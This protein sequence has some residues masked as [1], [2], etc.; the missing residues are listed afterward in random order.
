MSTKR[1]RQGRQLGRAA[2][3]TWAFSVAAV[4]VLAPLGPVGSALAQAPEIE[5]PRTAPMAPPEAPASVR[6]LIDAPYLT[7]DE[8]RD[9]RIFFGR[10]RKDDL[11]TPERA[12]RA[13][14]MR[15]AYDDPALASPEA[16]V[17][18]R[19][20]ALIRR[21]DLNGAIALVRERDE[22]RAR[23]IHAAA[24][25]HM[26]RYPEALEVAARGIATFLKAPPTS[27]DDAV[28][29]VR[30]MTLRLRLAGAAVGAG[31]DQPVAAGAQRIAGDFQGL[32]QILGDARQRLD[33]LH[34]PALLAE[35]ELLYARDNKPKAQEALAELL[36]L[37]PSCADGWRLLG[38][39]TVDGFNFDRSEQVAARLNLLAS[40]GYDPSGEAADVPAGAASIAGAEI[41]AR[42]MLRQ[43]DGEQAVAVLE[44]VLA[45]YP[46]V[47]E[48]LALQA[49]A[50]AVRFDDAARDAALKAFDETVGA[51][52]AALY[53][54]GRALAEARQYAPAA[55]HLD[56]AHQRQ[57]LA[58]EPLIERGLVEVQAGR[59]EQALSAL[60]RAF[61]VDP[62]NLRADNTLRLLREMRSY[63]RIE[64]PHFVVRFKPAEPGA[65]A[66]D[67]ILASEMPEVLEAN[68][69]VVTGSQPGGI[70]HQL[71]EGQKTIID[72]MPNHEWFGVRIAG[73]P[74]IHTVAA[75]TGPVIAMESPRDGP[76]HLGP[77]DWAR[78][79]R[80]EYVHTITL[81]RSANRIP[82]WFTEASATY[83]EQ[84]P[85]DYQTCLMLARAIDTDALF[86]FT[87]LNVAFVRPKRPEDRS[88][89]YNQGEWMYAFMI[90]RYGHRSPLDLMDLYAQGIREEEAFQRVL[91]VS[92]ATFFDAFKSWAQAQAESWGL[93]RKPGVPSVRE[94]LA[95]AAGGGAGAGAASDAH[96]ATMD[97]GP[98]AQPT[99]A[100]IDAW[101]TEYPDH[102]D[103]LELKLDA[104][105]N[106]AGGR[107]TPELVPLIER[108]AAARPVDPKPHRLLAKMYLDRAA[109]D[110]ANLA[111]EAARAIPHLDFLDQRETR[112]P[113]YAVE[114]ARRHAALDDLP[115]A[116]RSAVRATRLAPFN[117]AVR[118]LAATIAIQSKNYPA[119]EAQLRALAKIEPT[120]EL[121]Q[122]RLEALGKLRA[123]EG[124]AGE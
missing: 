80:H 56:R 24:L 35:A 101:L 98:A 59:D 82:H 103:V 95:R 29:G 110:P 105:L 15:G 1:S 16:D 42:A 36:A 45:R 62:F 14:L 107:A 50:H 122:R 69:A 51:S 77:Y 60:E 48:L 70:D 86:D 21:G 87:Y 2:R 117:A 123:R 22:L 25:E 121:H 92:R 3:L 89:A 96:A 4:G 114:L 30:L 55:D 32:M 40:D 10:W 6:A 102:P 72:L 39:L 49:A 23:R 63:A 7:P 38:R 43:I 28:E 106:A 68:H 37:N 12:A 111:A 109:A 91:K 108:Y 120:R 5:G 27:P 11:N 118:E 8:A 116:W 112:T 66:P 83:L 90:E 17:L 104:A 74:R 67:E 93:V 76:G 75:S 88:Q 115:A 119:A 81:S 97:D 65:A 71:P 34:W 84:A 26:A 57:P 52:P 44:P 18:D 19:A 33:R 53:E 73:M 13:A 46:G 64:T 20:E 41:I 100:Q 124:G 54:V 9:K 99:P 58:P 113:A 78:V 31:G 85:R 47:P 61:E 79:L 94:L